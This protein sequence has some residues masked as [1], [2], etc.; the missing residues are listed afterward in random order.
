MIE[1]KS[2]QCYHHA[3]ADSRM[4]PKRTST[5]AT[6]TVMQAAIRNKMHKVFPQPVMEFPLPEEVPT[7]SEE[8]SHCQKK[9][10]A[11]V[12][13]IHTATKVKK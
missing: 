6:P 8:C 9:R 4:P 13:K 2:Y 5:S 7:A 10:D 1:W 3:N 12:V 11:T